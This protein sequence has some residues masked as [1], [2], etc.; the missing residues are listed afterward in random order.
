[1]NNWNLILCIA[2]SIFH[3]QISS[4][5]LIPHSGRHFKIWTYTEDDISVKCHKMT[6]FKSVNVKISP[7]NFPKHIL[8]M[9]STFLHHLDHI[10]GKIQELLGFLME[11]LSTIIAAKQYGFKIFSVNNYLGSISSPTGHLVQVCLVQDS[12]TSSTS[13][14]DVVRLQTISTSICIC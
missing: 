12:R 8:I 3:I 7:K 1:M 13:S 6:S 5:T 9:F 14:L 4:Y 10:F 2:K 11:T